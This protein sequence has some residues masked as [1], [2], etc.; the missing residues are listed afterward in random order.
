M[1]LFSFVKEAGEKLWDSVSA[2]DGS[3][4]QDHLKAGHS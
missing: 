1:G 2:D 4:I 3:K